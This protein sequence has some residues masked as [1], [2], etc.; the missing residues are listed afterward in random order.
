MWYG[1]TCSGPNNLRPPNILISVKQTFF[2]TLLVSSLVLQLRWGSMLFL[3][4]LVISRNIKLVPSVDTAFPEK[5]ILMTAM[6]ACYQGVSCAVTF[7]PGPSR[8]GGQRSIL[9]FTFS[10]TRRRDAAALVNWSTA[11]LIVVESRSMLVFPNDGKGP[12]NR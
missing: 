8:V 5:R 12:K 1:I 3:N 7:W 9:D 11:F 10:Q 6:T 4:S 2:H